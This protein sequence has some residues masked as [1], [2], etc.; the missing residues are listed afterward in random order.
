MTSEM[1][2]TRAAC[3]QLAAPHGFYSE[4]QIS[5]SL[6]TYQKAISNEYRASTS[7]Q[8]RMYKN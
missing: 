7:I 5:R 2:S 4:K 1:T 3:S 6:G 8:S